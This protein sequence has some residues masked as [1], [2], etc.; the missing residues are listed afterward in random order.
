MAESAAASATTTR[1]PCAQ[2]PR[3][4]RKL[5]AVHYMLQYLPRQPVSQ[6]VCQ[7]QRLHDGLLVPPP[8]SP[9]RPAVIHGSAASPLST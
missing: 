6:H 2:L 4:V 7:V 1:R 3:T 8:L 5:Y 9:P